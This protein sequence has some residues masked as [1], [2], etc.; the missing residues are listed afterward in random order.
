VEGEGEE[1]QG[2]G[3][4][5]F[6]GE[7]KVDFWVAWDWSTSNLGDFLGRRGDDGRIWFQG[8]IEEGVGKYVRDGTNW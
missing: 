7:G 5:G 6:G 2:G 1:W 4:A 8:R 3:G